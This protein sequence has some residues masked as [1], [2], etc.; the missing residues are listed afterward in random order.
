MSGARLLRCEMWTRDDPR[1][2]WALVATRFPAPRADHLAD[3]FGGSFA[4]ERAERLAELAKK[5]ELIGTL[6]ARGAA[7]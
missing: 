4:V 6:R 3:P 7:P 5:A 1:G 2:R